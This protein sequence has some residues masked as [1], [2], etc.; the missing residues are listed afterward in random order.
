MP[1]VPPRQVLIAGGGPAALE[2]A[3][4]LQSR[5]G[6]LVAVTLLAPDSEFVYRPL[7][8]GEPFGVARPRRFSLAA[9]AAERGFGLRRDHVVAVEPDAHIAVTAGGDRVHYDVLVL[10]IGAIPVEAVPGALTFRGP[11]DVQALQDALERIPAG[12]PARVAFVAPPSAAWTLPAYELA[13][14]TAAW[15]SDREMRIEPWVITHE[16]LPLGV[17]GAEAS[18]AVKALLSTRHV[19]VWT[20][21]AAE[22]FEDGRLW[23]EM[24]GGIPVAAAVALPRM[25][26]RPVPGLPRDEEGFTPTDDLGQV[27][28]VP[29]VFAVGD[30]TMRPIKQ[31]GLATAQADAAVSAIAAEAGAD[32]EPAPYAPRLRAVLL[33]G[34]APLYLQR[35]PGVAGQAAD[36]APW[37]P[38]HKIAGYHLAPYLAAHPEVE[39]GRAP[40]LWGESG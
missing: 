19:L 26:G 40:V 39:S 28:G 6:D 8:V 1:T 13:M 33:T 16:T 20:G 21:A 3:L 10:A 30:M 25:V 15:S 14:L 36:D 7:A 23:V 22:R 31:G 34:G 11:A 4:G 38:P 35:S 29:D 5:A 27:P 12:R 32:A 17:F 24:E 9:I 18:A 37:W 2:T